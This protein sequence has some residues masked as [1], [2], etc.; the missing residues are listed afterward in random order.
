MADAMWSDQR[1]ASRFSN[2]GVRLVMWRTSRAFRLPPSHT[3]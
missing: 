1:S 2:M 3:S